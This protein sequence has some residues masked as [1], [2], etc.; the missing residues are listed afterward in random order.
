MGGFERLF[1]FGDLMWTDWIQE[2]IGQTRRRSKLMIDAWRGQVS[3]AALE[4]LRGS[5]R[6]FDLLWYGED[7]EW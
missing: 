4:A 5:Y 1:D 2:F 6:R 3:P 7:K